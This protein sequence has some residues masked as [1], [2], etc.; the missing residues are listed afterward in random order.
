MLGLVH[1]NSFI[2]I[3]MYERHFNIKLMNLPYR[4]HINAQHDTNGGRFE[5]KAKHLMIIDTNSSDF[6]P[7]QFF[8]YLRNNLVSEIQLW[9]QNL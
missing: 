8:G 4:T 9:N 2:E 7:Q 1:I 6:P 3:T 5:R